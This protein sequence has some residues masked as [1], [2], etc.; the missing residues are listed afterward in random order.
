M[1]SYG[2]L[3]RDTEIYSDVWLKIFLIK[4]HMTRQKLRRAMESYGDIGIGMVRKF[5]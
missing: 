3:W 2:E 1:E 5:L 4:L